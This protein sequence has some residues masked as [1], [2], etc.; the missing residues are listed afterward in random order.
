M[1][2]AAR[3][4]GA[5]APP[6]HA[7]AV[8]FATAFLLFLQLRVLDEFKDH[9]DD[10]RYRPYRPVPRGLVTLRELGW[11]ALGAAIVQLVL[12][13]S[14]NAA[15]LVWLAGVWVYI[16]L[17]RV[18]FF[19][20]RWLNAHPFAYMASH[21]IVVPLIALYITAC[22]WLQAMPSPPRSLVWFLLASFCNGIVIE[23]GRKV[24]APGDEEPGVATYSAA[25]GTRR[26]VVGWVAA[27]LASAALAL[28]A[29]TRIGAATLAAL[30]LI[31]AMTLTV[32]IGWD[33]ARAPSAARSRRV[34]HASGVW[35]LLLYLV[36]GV[37][38]LVTRA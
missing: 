37:A 20:H 6:P 8:A 31:P 36:L 24:R 32:A 34:E 30:I 15:L 38:P 13:V 19:A 18:E 11:I 4:R 28:A 23:I 26:A 16:G 33:F 9:D 3:L 22:E 10:V 7:A 17:M 12:A 29:A 14:L 5:T 27:L 21:M 1:S 2:Y 25:W 35:A